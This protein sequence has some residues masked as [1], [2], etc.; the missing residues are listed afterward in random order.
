MIV[1]DLNFHIDSLENHDT[2]QFLDLL[3]YTSLVQHVN[4]S[5]HELGHTHDLIITRSSDANF[6]TLLAA[7]SDIVLSPVIF[8]SG[9]HLEKQNGDL[10]GSSKPPISIL[11]R[12][13]CWNQIYCCILLETLMTL[14]ALITLPCLE[15]HAPLK[16]K[17]S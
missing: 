10:L 3:E 14:L 11:S 9:G 16:S 15:K 7:D 6:L 13:T 8:V 5:T 12:M 1:E 2:G 17:S 4:I